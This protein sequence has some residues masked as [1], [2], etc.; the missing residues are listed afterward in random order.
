MILQVR[1]YTAPTEEPVSLAEMK[2]HLRVDHS[3]EDALIAGLITAAR[4]QCELESRRTFC[5]ATLEQRWERWPWAGGFPLHRGPVQSITSITY[6][7]EDGTTGTM[8]SSDYLLYKETDPATVVLK[9]GA[10]WPAVDLMPG[11]SIAVRYVAGYGAAAAVPQRYKQAI[12]LMAAHWYE[13][14]EPVVVGTIVTQLPLAVRTLL[15]TDRAGY[16]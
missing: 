1:T 5:T 15:D 3:D 16:F 7:D 12:K 2:L 11:A 14:R 9:P 8:S 13:N 4:E 6:T 10:E